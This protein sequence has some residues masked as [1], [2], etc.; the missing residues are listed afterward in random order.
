MS[1][2]STESKTN[3]G[4]VVAPASATTWVVAISRHLI[5]GACFK[6]KTAAVDYA[7]MLASAAGLGRAKIKVL[8]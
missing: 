4:L 1:R 6:T 8:S 2:L 7:S 5:P 3:K